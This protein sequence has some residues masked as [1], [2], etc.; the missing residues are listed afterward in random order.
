MP[1]YDEALPTTGKDSMVIGDSKLSALST[2]ADLQ[3]C[4][5]RYLTPLALV[6]KT[7]EDRAQWVDAAVTGTGS[8]TRV[9]SASADGMGRGDEVGREQTYRAGDSPGTVN[10]PARGLVRQSEE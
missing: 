10:W 4:G 7:K 5:S 6:G 8:L 3:G 9:Q 1:A 2:R